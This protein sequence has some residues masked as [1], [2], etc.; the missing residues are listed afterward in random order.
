MVVDGH[1]EMMRNYWATFVPDAH[2]D[3]LVSMQNDRVYK[4]VGIPTLPKTHKRAMQNAARDKKRKAGTA[5]SAIDENASEL[6][7][8]QAGDELILILERMEVKPVNAQDETA[9]QWAYMLPNFL[10]DSKTGPVKM[11]FPLNGQPQHLMDPGSSSYFVWQLVPSI[12]SMS[13]RSC[14]D[15][16][17]FWR[18]GVVHQT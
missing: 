5:S 10:P 7:V 12:A 16:K 18:I 9:N 13:N 15:R 11:T 14:W 8:P 1:V 6:V 4:G 2:E 3:D 17:G